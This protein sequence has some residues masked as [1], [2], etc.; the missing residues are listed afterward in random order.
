MQIPLAHWKTVVDPEV[1]N[2]VIFGLKPLRPC[3]IGEMADK[4]CQ[5]TPAAGITLIG[6]M[7]EKAGFVPLYIVVETDK[8]DDQANEVE[9]MSPY[10]VWVGG[11][12]LHN[13]RQIVERAMT[14][15]L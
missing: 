2:R 10:V 5:V 3:F 4:I 1:P 9:I 11:K 6:R 12:P 15:Q 7:S 13:I 8:V 14:Q